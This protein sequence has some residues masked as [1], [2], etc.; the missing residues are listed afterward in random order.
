[1]IVLMK[2]FTKWYKRSVCQ[3]LTRELY[4]IFQIIAKSCASGSPMSDLNNRLQSEKIFQLIAFR[5]TPQ[6]LSGMRSFGFHLISEEFNSYCSVIP[7]MLLHC[8]YSITPFV[9]QVIH[10]QLYSDLPQIW[11]RFMELSSTFGPA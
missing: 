9:D 4:S 2:V 1:M 7:S 10:L 11:R 3:P 6:E 8:R 5:D